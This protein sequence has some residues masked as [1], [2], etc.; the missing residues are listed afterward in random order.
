MRINLPIALFSLAL[1]LA[2]D[3]VGQQD[4]QFTQ[5]PFGLQ[6]VN[7][8]V[9]GQE[10]GLRVGGMYRTQW[11]GLEGH[12]VS[13]LIYA[14]L[15][16]Y[17]LKSGA[18]LAVVN[19]KA[20]Q[21]NTLFAMASYSYNLKVGQGDL[22]LGLSAGIIQKSLDGSKLKAPQGDYEPGVIDHNDPYIPLSR[23]SDLTPDFGFGISYSLS[24]LYVGL[25]ATHV[26]SP[27]INYTIGNS[28]TEIAYTPHLYLHGQYA[29][30]L[31]EQLTLR[32]ALIMKS[33]LTIH[34]L[35]IN[36]ALLYNDNIWGGLSF[37]GYN[38]RSFDAVAGMIGLK[39]S[40]D[41]SFGYSYDINISALRVANGGSHELMINYFVPMAKPR[42]GKIINNPRFISF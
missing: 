14:N 8:A 37:R 13:Q 35:D 32:P 23:V 38:S 2:S 19:D 3:V 39:L 17:H 31:N 10:R 18:G 21:E 6:Q 36:A 26:M 33:D 24:D 25:A 42:K 12:P 15:P 30:Y 5:F 7:P 11:V 40:N 22:A 9:S 28:S 29:I 1:F 4:P 20:G 16:L 27:K 41:I 34:Q